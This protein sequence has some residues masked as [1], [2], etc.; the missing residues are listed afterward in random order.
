MSATLNDTLLSTY[1]DDCPVITVQG[2]MYPVSIKYIQDCHNIMRKGQLQQNQEN[3]TISNNTNSHST[4]TNS[5][6]SNNKNYNNNNKKK[7]NK[8]QLNIQTNNS[9]ASTTTTTNN[10]N[11]HSN[12]DNDEIIPPIFDAEYIAELILRIIQCHEYTN[13]SHD[14]NTNNKNTTTTTSATNTTTSTT[15]TS[16]TQERGNAIL[17]FL[18]GLQAINKVSYALRS[19]NILT[20]LNAY[21]LTLHSTT[22]FYMQKQ[23]FIPTEKYQWKIILATNIAETSITIDDITHVIDTGNIF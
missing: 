14:N 23:V 17:V 15:T 13:N 16:S 20:K 11:N 22:P 6:N 12:E 9:S 8:Q 19:R 18:S 2:R 21:V 7:A 4:T 1:F 5:T 3:Y 10:N